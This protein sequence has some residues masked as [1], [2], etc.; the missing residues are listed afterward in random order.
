MDTCTSKGAD[1]RQ[2]EVLLR[3]V[4][5]WLLL[6]LAAHTQRLYRHFLCAHG[7]AFLLISGLQKHM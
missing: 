4:S 5:P 1:W 6:S 7:H 3:P 2:D